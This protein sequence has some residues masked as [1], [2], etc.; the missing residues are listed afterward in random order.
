MYR[1]IGLVVTFHGYQFYTNRLRNAFT[2]F[3]LVTPLFLSL[4]YFFRVNKISAPNVKRN[5]YT[6]TI[7]MW[8]LF[9]APLSSLLTLQPI[10]TLVT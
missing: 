5:Y 7:E 4:Q 3:V 6:W 2:M 9:P 10:K 1:F 8:G